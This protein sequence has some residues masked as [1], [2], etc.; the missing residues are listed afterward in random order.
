MPNSDLSPTTKRLLAALESFSH[1]EDG[2]IGNDDWAGLVN[3]LDRELLLLQRLAQEKPAETPEFKQHA[4][5]L[6]QHFDQVAQRIAAAKARD[7]Q[8]LISLRETT[9]RM[10]AVRKTYLKP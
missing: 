8:E 10:H 2:A 1:Q 5:K 3:I 9:K 6:S 7:I 4:E